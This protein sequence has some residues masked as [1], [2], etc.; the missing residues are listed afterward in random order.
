MNI[1]H[2]Y[3][4]VSESKSKEWTIYSN[5]HW[6]LIHVLES[7]STKCLLGSG[8]WLCSI[9]K[10]LFDHCWTWPQAIFMW[11]VLQEKIHSKYYLFMMFSMNDQSYKTIQT[12]SFWY[13][14]YAQI[15]PFSSTFIAQ[16]YS[17]PYLGGHFY[18]LAKNLQSIMISIETNTLPNFHH[19]NTWIDQKAVCKSISPTQTVFCPTVNQSW[20]YLPIPLWNSYEW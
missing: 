18:R 7:L 8:M 10:Q 3:G 20:P 5:Y 19:M 14:V 17:Q 9:L 13:N 1:C 11:Q 6:K 2:I 4:Y 12:S 15:Q 16:I